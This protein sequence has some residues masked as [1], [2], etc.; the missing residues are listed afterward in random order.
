MV[1]ANEIA[2]RHNLGS[3]ATPIVN[4][5]ILGAF[6][7]ATGLVEMDSIFWAIDEAVPTHPEHNRQAAQDAYNETIAIEPAAGALARTLGDAS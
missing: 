2:W 5:A 3:R 4:T 6:A 1:N 7:R